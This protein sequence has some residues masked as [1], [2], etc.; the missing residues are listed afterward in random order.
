MLVA[1]EGRGLTALFVFTGSRSS[2]VVGSFV[3]GS[4]PVSCRPGEQ[5]RHQ[6]RMVPSRG[7]RMSTGAALGKG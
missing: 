2:S 6:E 7:A 3:M 4:F 1:G 5:C